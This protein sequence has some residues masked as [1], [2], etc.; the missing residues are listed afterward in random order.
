MGILD[1]TPG[2]QFNPPPGTI[3]MLRCPDGTLLKYWC[4]IRCRCSATWRTHAGTRSPNR[5]RGRP[6]P[7]FQNPLWVAYQQGAPAAITAGDL[8]AAVPVYIYESGGV[9]PP[10]NSVTPDQAQT[11]IWTGPQV[12]PIAADTPS[13]ASTSGNRFRHNLG[14]AC[15]SPPGTAVRASPSTS[16]SPGTP[17]RCGTRSPRTRRRPSSGPDRTPRR[18][19]AGYAVNDVDFW[20]A[21]TV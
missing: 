20:L 19:A 17:I 3:L 5:L 16:T 1:Y 21:T 10:R 9:Y 13:T 7:I 14:A 11:V 12:P 8:P 6:V 4:R 2:G 15:R 18:S